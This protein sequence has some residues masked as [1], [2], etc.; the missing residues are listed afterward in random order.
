M[1]AYFRVCTILTTYSRKLLIK[2]YCRFRVG[3]SILLN[4]TAIVIHFFY[5]VKH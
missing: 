2:G 5:S 4:I 3:I 1:D